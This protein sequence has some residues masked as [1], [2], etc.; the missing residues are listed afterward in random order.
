LMSYLSVYDTWRRD[1]G[2]L[3][4]RLEEAH[5]FS[6]DKTRDGRFN[7]A[8]NCDYYYDETLTKDELLQLAEEL[9]EMADG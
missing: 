9:K 7:V 1:M 2:R 4:D 3:L 6:V 8:E 5:V